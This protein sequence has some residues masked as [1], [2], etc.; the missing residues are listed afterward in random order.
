[1]V[2]RRRVLAAR[3][4]EQTAGDRGRSR[5][6]RTAFERLDVAEAE[7][8]ERREVETADRAC[9]VAERVGAR[10]AEVG[11]VRQRTRTHRV[12]HDHA[13]A[14]QAYGPGNSVGV[15]RPVLGTLASSTHSSLKR[16]PGAILRRVTTALGL[17]GVAVFIVCVVALAAGVTWT[18]VRLSPA[19]GGDK[20]KPQDDAADPA[21]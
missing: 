2:T 17:I 14:R 4:L 5:L 13:R 11:R 9:D 15:L 18:V 6:R 19:P 21:T 16:T 20:P 7:R 10:V 8:L 3:P 12:E 1:P